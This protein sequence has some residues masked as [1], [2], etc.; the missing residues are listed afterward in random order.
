M[1]TK[2]NASEIYEKW[3]QKIPDQFVDESIRHYSNLNLCDPQQRDEVVF[4]LFQFNIY[5]IDFWLSKVVL[6]NE[7]KSFENKLMCTAWDL[8]SELMD[9]RVTGFS[10]TNDTKNIL[11]L[12]I[13]QNDLPELERT[14]ENVR[15][16]L[17]RPENQDYHQLPANVSAKEILKRLVKHSIPVL[18]DTGAL[19]LELSNKHVADE[20]LRNAPT[21]YEA[22]VYFDESDVLQTIDRNGTISEFDCSVYR[23]NLAHCLVYLDD[24]HTRG[25]DLKFPLGWKASVTLSGEITRDKTVQACMRMRQL[26]NGHSIAFWASFEADLR[27]REICKLS[28]DDPPNN[29]HVI[30]FIENNSKRFET[31]NTVHWTYAAYNYT[32]KMSGYKLFQESDHLQDLYD[33]CEEKEFVTLRDMYSDKKEET[34]ANLALAKYKRLLNLY[35]HNDNISAF[36]ET[37]HNAVVERLNGPAGDIK[38]CI[39]MMD[40]EQESEIDFEP[41]QQRQIVKPPKVKPYLDVNLDFEKLQNLIKHGLTGERLG[42]DKTGLFTIVNALKNTKLFH[43]Y[44]ADSNAFSKNIFVTHDFINVI[45]SCHATDRFLRP[46]WWIARVSDDSDGHILILMSSL[47]SHHLLPTFLRSVKST[48]YMFRP[49]LNKT[50]SELVD[51]VDLRITGRTN[52]VDI[53]ARSLS[54]IKVYSG[55]IYFKNQTEQDAYCH[56]LGLIPRPRTP[57]LDEAFHSGIIKPN[58]FVSSEHR[59]HSEEIFECVGGCKFN[60]NPVNLAIKLIEAH[61]QCIRKESHAALILERG[62]KSELPQ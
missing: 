2:Q 22:A 6:P 34:V 60:R 36:I 53:D 1:A 15:K 52:T 11:P 59:N 25:T 28:A 45:R 9:H 51:E 32:K 20:W 17:M 62:L 16:T 7:A 47:Q 18:L 35:S 43:E 50:C 26:G 14:N 42:M 5:A 13:A 44:E 56:F 39:N 29:E 8:C 19:M 33:G 55:S 46:A 58:G 3:I 48:L 23:E 38:R 12:P 24:T 49:R 21:T 61:H 57:T 54:E 27:I 41:E 4:P 30:K 40:E 10:G 37:T 31:E